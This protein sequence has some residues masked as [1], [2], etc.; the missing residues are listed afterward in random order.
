MMGPIPNR[1]PRHR[2][3]EGR[4]LPQKL[5]VFVPPCEPFVRIL[6]SKL[7]QA[8]KANLRGLGYGI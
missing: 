6:T 5:C 4:H 2:D 8:I 3:T 1:T 7:E